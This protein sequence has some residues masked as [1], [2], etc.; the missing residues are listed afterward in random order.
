MRVERGGCNRTNEHAIDHGEREQD[1]TYRAQTERAHVHPSSCPPR[2]IDQKFFLS[3]ITT[4]TTTTTTSNLN[5][6]TPRQSHSLTPPAPTPTLP[7]VVRSVRTYAHV[8]PPKRENRGHGYFFVFLPSTNSTLRFT[9]GGQ[10]Q[11]IKRGNKETKSEQVS[12]A[13]KRKY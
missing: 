1:A 13:R 2:R 12:G 4:T 9:A 10:K 3:V 5:S 7:R 6:F 11:I 8:P